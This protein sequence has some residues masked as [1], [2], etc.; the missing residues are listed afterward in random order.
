MSTG[1][2]HGF[3][4]GPLERYTGHRLLVACGIVMLRKGF[5]FLLHRLRDSICRVRCVFLAREVFLFLFHPDGNV[6]HTAHGYS[7]RAYS[8][9]IILQFDEYGDLFAAAYPDIPAEELH[10]AHAANAIAAFEIDA[11][12]FHDSPWDRFLAGDD[13]ALDADQL[14]GAKLFYG[15]AKCSDCHSGR[16]MTDQEAHNIGIIPIGPGP[17]L[18]KDADYGG[19]PYWTDG[20]D[21]QA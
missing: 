14:A 16:L 2:V 7:R 8:F 10:F 3:R 6:A 1:S 9:L 15:K 21:V 17:D 18:D 5:H 13:Q 20:A 11:F 19:G 12:T 4:H